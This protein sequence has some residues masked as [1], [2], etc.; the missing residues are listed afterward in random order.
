MGR[1]DSK[2]ALFL[3]RTP[4]TEHDVIGRA[5]DILDG[6]VR[7]AEAIRADGRFSPEGRHGEITKALG[8]PRE[9]LNA[10]QGKI[11]GRR[12]VLR[13]QREGL[14]LKAP[15]RA[16]L[17]AEMQRA[18][19]RAFLRA[20]P[21]TERIRIA[22]ETKDPTIREAIVHA[23]PELSGLKADTH[24]LV[25]SAMLEGLHGPQLKKLGA[26][27]AMLADVE[28]G[29]A[30]ALADVRRESGL[31]ADQFAAAKAA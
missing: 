4:A 22:I 15:D 14:A 24:E 25:R 27:D 31:S 2:R 18:E 19:A 11:A 6:F 3:T 21:E 13:Q 1:Y 9:Q 8:A 5:Y 12:E 23:S 30:E 26:D 10:L 28:A 16:D 20:Q 7:T 29:I 17:F